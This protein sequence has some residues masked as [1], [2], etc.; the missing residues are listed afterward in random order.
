MFYDSDRYDHSNSVLLTITF[1][2][3]PTRQARMG[4]SFLLEFISVTPPRE[5]IWIMDPGPMGTIRCANTLAEYKQKFVIC[6]SVGKQFTHYFKFITQ[7]LAKHYWKT[8]YSQDMALIVWYAKD[9]QNKPKY[10]SFLTNINGMNEGVDRIKPHRAPQRVPRAAEFYNMNKNGVD[11]ADHL[12]RDVSHQHRAHHSFIAKGLAF[13]LTLWCGSYLDYVSV[14][15]IPKSSF[16][17]KDYSLQALQQEYDQLGCLVDQPILSLR[18]Q[19]SF[20]IWCPLKSQKSKRVC[21]NPTC[22]KR[23]NFCCKCGTHLC[24]DLCMVGFH[25]PKLRILRQYLV[26]PKGLTGDQNFALPRG[27]WQGSP[28][29]TGSRSIGY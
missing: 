4:H 1:R 9:S 12:L 18:F 7:D 5:F 23:T 26:P 20:I 24:S 21:Q 2:S 29:W 3:L 8:L 28:D 25:N 6:I 17:L 27:I 10:V 11:T 14:H 13:L 22:S 16:T 19:P 15:G